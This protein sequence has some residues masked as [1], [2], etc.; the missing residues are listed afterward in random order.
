MEW[1]QQSSLTCCCGAACSAYD[2]AAASPGKLSAK[3]IV[4]EGLFCSAC[5]N[6][7]CH[8]CMREHD[9]AVCGALQR[10]DYSLQQLQAAAVSQLTSQHIVRQWLDVRRYVLLCTPVFFWRQSNA[11]WLVVAWMQLQT[12][13]LSS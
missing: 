12:N 5:C 8:G 4:E 2:I 11:C 3:Q 7:F 13:C 10:G 1:Q 6:V 9:A